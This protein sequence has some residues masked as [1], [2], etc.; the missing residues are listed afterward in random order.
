MD[1]AA[2][3]D[4]IL[5]GGNFIFK[6]YIG[7]KSL[8]ETLPIVT[9]YRSRTTD[10]QTNLNLCWSSSDVGDYEMGVVILLLK[11]YEFLQHTGNLNKST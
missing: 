6:T 8:P 3:Q 2:S 9:R 11:L 4:F 10:K 7:W 1:H 5:Y